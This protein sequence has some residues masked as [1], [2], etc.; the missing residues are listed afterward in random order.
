MFRYPKP[1]PKPLAEGSSEHKGMMILHI[2]ILFM[3]TPYSSKSSFLDSDWNFSGWNHKMS[4]GGGPGVSWNHIEVKI[5]FI[6]LVCQYRFPVDV[7]K[8][9]IPWKF[10]S[11]KQSGCGLHGW[12][13]KDSRSYQSDQSLV[14]LE[15]L[16]IAHFVNGIF[17]D[18]QG[19]GTPL[20]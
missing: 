16:G 2:D 8:K 7:Q 6:L 13:G 10:L 14:D 5:V 12:W 9:R 15:F 4:L 17:R 1:T 11:T 20:W 3:F 19:H 18:P